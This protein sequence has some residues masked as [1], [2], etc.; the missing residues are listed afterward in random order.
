MLDQ[1][2]VYN[3]SIIQVVILYLTLLV[4]RQFWWWTLHQLH[5]LSLLLRFL[6][7]NLSSFQ[8]TLRIDFLFH[9]TSLVQVC[10]VSLLKM[11]GLLQIDRLTALPHDTSICGGE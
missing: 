3:L 9:R 4:Q 10:V 6:V 11:Y 2:L 1:S 8:K 7:E 5:N